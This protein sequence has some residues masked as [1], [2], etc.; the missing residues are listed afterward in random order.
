MGQV[1]LKAH[2]KHA[3]GEALFPAESKARLRLFVQIPERRRTH[4]YEIAV[5][6]LYRGEEV[7]R[8]TWQLAPPRKEDH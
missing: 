8:V 2:G 1:P 4:P 6:Q 3:L 5:R 7:G